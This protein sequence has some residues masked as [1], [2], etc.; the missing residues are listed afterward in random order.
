MIEVIKALR[1]K[2]VRQKQTMRKPYTAFTDALSKVTGVS[3]PV[4]GIQWQPPETQRQ[5]ARRV[6]AFCEDRRILFAPHNWEMKSECVHS[7]TEIRRFLT[8]E[9]GR[10]D[11]DLELARRLEQMRKAC[12]IFMDSIRESEID[13]A[14]VWTGCNM[15][16]GVSWDALDALR[17]C[18]GHQIFW[19]MMAYGLE[20]EEDLAQ[21]FPDYLKK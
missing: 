6:I 21:A 20:V 7:A 14:R 4:F 13:G 8:E 5:V 1:V 2:A 11:R 12:R 18:F 17:I 15:V 19:I 9:L 3:I 16:H 10:L